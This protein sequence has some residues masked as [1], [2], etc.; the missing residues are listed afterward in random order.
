MRK[1]EQ[2]Q[3]EEAGKNGNEK[4]QVKWRNTDKREPTNVD[5]TKSADLDLTDAEKKVMSA[6]QLEAHAKKL[7][8]N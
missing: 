4:D 1:K 6:D 7:I 8:K 3:Q 2:V 5:A